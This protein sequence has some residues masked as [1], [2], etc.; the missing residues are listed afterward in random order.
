MTRKMRGPRPAFVGAAALAA[1]ALM[2]AGCSGPGTG[3]GGTP[4]A[5]DQCGVVPK[6]APNDPHGLLADFSDDVQ[7]M[8]NAYPVKVQASALADFK[9]SKSSGWTAALVGMPPTNP[10][11]TNLQKGIVSDLKANG[12]DVIADY[13]P[14]DVTN[15]PLQIQQLQE[16]IALKPDVI[17]YIPIAPEP[18]LETV[19]AAYEAGIPVVA[20][21][22]S[23]DSPY[24]VSVAMNTVLQAMVTGAGVLKGSRGEGDV[25]HI[26]GVPSSGTSADAAAGFNH[27]LKNCPGLNDP[28]EISGLFDPSV[29]QAEVL[30]FLA[31]HPAG[32]AAVLQDGTMG[33]PALKAFQE[34]GATTIPPIND[35]GASQGFA[36]WALQNKDYPYF[37]GTTSAEQQAAAT[38]S[39]GK[40][41]LAGGGPKVNQIA[42]TPVIIDHSNLADIADPSWPVTDMTDL[43][44]PPG[45]LLPPAQLDQFF[46]NTAAGN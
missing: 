20:T 3:G 28:I 19:K 27:V 7:E 34:A 31:S 43:K 35:S 30:K 10:F 12:F 39:V 26:V 2:L 17:F 24:G 42:F 29:T 37:G 8:Y 11:L 1:G 5:S 21:Q 36:S 16:A 22:S 38:V 4:N 41:I 13:A 6:I 40:R 14:D 9:S 44:N 23:L 46:T 32:V 15:V 18:A 45:T 33:L 25:L